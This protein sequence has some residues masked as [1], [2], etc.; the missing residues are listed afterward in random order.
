MAGSQLQAA[1]HQALH[2]WIEARPGIYE[3]QSSCEARI[4]IYSFDR[5]RGTQPRPASAA[6]TCSQNWETDWKGWSGPKH[7]WGSQPGHLDLLRS[8]P[9]NLQELPDLLSANRTR[10]APVAACIGWSL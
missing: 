1:G 9:E 10:P 7:G 6:Q 8:A 2:L 5:G 3:K 4:D